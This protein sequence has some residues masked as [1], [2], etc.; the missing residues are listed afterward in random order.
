MEHHYEYGTYNSYHTLLINKQC[1]N[2]VALKT[3]IILHSLFL[4]SLTYISTNYAL[5]CASQTKLEYFVCAVV[6][7]TWIKYM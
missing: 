2:T 7:T 6:V 1:S 4:Q 5:Y 3:F